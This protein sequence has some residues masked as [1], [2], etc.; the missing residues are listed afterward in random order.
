MA[1]ILNTFNYHWDHGV[2]KRNEKD[3]KIKDFKVNYLA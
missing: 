1:L 3:E 2:N